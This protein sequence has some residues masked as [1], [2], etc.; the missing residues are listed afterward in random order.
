MA[1]NSRWS[2]PPEGLWVSPTGKMEPVNERL[3]AIAERPD[4]FGLAPQEVKGADELAL[5]KLAER[6]IA[7]GWI[8]FRYLD[9]VYNFEVDEARRRMDI[10]KNVLA[11]A[12]A[13]PEESVFI[14]QFSPPKEFQG[15]VGDVYDSHILRLANKKRLC[16]WAFSYGWPLT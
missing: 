14:S 11:Q 9:G 1:K 5:R 13:I 3:M 12:N 7:Q 8:R 2:L 4:L 15:T 10:I 16:K 6:L